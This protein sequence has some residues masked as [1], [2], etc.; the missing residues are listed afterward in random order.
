MTVIPLNYLLLPPLTLS[1]T[2]RA[3][4]MA[5][6][7]NTTDEWQPESKLKPCI[8]E[9]LRTN[10]CQVGRILLVEKIIQVPM[11]KA[12]HQSALRLYLSDGEKN[13]QG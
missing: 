9:I 1:T 13:I 3:D 4:A 2:N 12:K 10:Y 6:P 8:A 11:A 5:S 7:K